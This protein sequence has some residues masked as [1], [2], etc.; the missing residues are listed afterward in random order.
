M[1]RPADTEAA[2]TEDDED[3]DEEADTFERDENGDGEEDE[4]EDKDDVTDERDSDE[5]SAN[6]AMTTTTTTTTESVEEVVR[7][8]KWI[9]THFVCFHL[10]VVFLVCVTFLFS[11]N[12]RSSHFALFHFYL[13]FNLRSPV[14]TY[15]SCLLGSSRVRPVSR[16]AGALVLHA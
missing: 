12:S 9:H 3:E 10:L 5:R 7:G 4:E 1:S 16:H 2:T 6:V 13:I 11:I 15:L 14:C 8:K